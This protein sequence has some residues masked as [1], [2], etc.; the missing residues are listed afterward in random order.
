MSRA[1]FGLAGIASAGQ[2]HV[3]RSEKP[4]PIRA[5]GNRFSEPIA[6]GAPLKSAGR[7]RQAETTDLMPV[8]SPT[9]SRESKQR[10]KAHRREARKRAEKTRR[11]LAD[12]CAQWMYE[13]EDA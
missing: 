11:Q 3:R 10:A 12:H 9:V 2:G 5:A 6:A 8:Q 4:L 13:A 1:G 7:V